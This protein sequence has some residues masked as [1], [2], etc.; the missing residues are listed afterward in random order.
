MTYGIGL[1]GA[2]QLVRRPRYAYEVAGATRTI[3][4][5]VPILTYP[6]ICVTP[7]VVSHTPEFL[8][9]LKLTSF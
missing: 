5:L 9:M 8:V 1:C 4:M 3:D 7:G 2:V 6:D